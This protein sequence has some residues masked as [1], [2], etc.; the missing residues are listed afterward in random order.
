MT[1]ILTDETISRIE[2]AFKVYWLSPFCSGTIEIGETLLSWALQATM[3]SSKAYADAYHST[4]QIA[5]QIKTGLITSPVTFARLTTP[6]QFDLVNSINQNDIQHLGDELLEWVRN[7]IEEPK[8]LL[9]AK[10]V[11]VARIIYTKQGDF[12]YYE[13]L[14]DIN[15]YL[16]QD[17]EWHWSSKG[18]ALEGYRNRVKWFSW[19]PQG[20]Q[21]TKN[22]NQL[23]YHGENTFLP[24]VGSKNRHDFRLGTHAQIPFD[25][26]FVALLNLIDQHST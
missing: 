22:Q 11:R 6:S 14:M 24:S 18:N 16:S 12:T 19:Y 26:M 25:K 3:L 2:L 5:Y 15:H 23:H 17:Y 4:N 21:G 9:G 1:I 20:R 10:E 13:R 8:I 7:R